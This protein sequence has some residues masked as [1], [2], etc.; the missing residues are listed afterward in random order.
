[1]IC[2]VLS[3]HLQNIFC[4]GDFPKNNASWSSEG[5]LFEEDQQGVIDDYGAGII[6]HDDIMSWIPRINYVL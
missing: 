3:C 4:G 2:V 5:V 1:M 6:F